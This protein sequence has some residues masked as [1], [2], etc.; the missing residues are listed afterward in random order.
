MLGCFGESHFPHSLCL[1]LVFILVWAENTL[2]HRY[3]VAKEISV[4]TTWFAKTGYSERSPIQKS[5]SG[6]WFHFIFTEPLVLIL[7]EEQLLAWALPL[8]YV[9]LSWLLHH[10]YRYQHEQQL[11]LATHPVLSINP[12]EGT[13]TLSI[14]G[15]NDKLSLVSGIP[16]RE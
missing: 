10:Q 15:H 11:C 7:I 4:L 13:R 2:S 12:A 6:F 8:H 3:V 9:S 16:S 5:A 1:Y 14:P